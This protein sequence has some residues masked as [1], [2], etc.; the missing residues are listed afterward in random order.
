MNR[1]IY[2]IFLISFFLLTTSGLVCSQNKELPDSVKLNGKYIRGYFTNTWAMIKSPANWEEKDWRN[3]GM[4]GAA[5]FVLYIFDEDIVDW[6][7]EIRSNESNTVSDIFEPFGNS[8][9]L[10]PFS[11]LFGT[12]GIGV[13]T[14]DYRLKKSSLVALQSFA[15]SGF[16]TQAIKFAVNRDRPFRGHRA[17]PSGHTSA[18]WSVAAVFAYEYKDKMWVAPVA[19]SLATLT[20]LSRINDLRHWPTDV[21]FGFALGYFTG[22]YISRIHDRN[23]EKNLNLSLS[24][25]YGNEFKGLSLVYR[26]R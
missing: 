5:T 16:F 10:M 6:V 17:F 20:S 19:Y 9:V 26:F 15:I 14:K 18:V 4:T 12:Y 13:L 23:V 2:I 21:V 25:F 22:R 1:V 24:P 8:S 11:V 7:S 3:F